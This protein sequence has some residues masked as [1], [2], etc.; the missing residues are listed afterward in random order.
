MNK[1]KR[2]RILSTM[3]TVCVLASSVSPVDVFAKGTEGG[4]SRIN[5]MKNRK[6]HTRRQG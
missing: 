4:I 3:L 5:L 2:K 6:V 1:K